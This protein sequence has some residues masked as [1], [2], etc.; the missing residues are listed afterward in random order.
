MSP[1]ARLE[2]SG[3][4]G[5]L[6]GNELAPAGSRRLS[7]RLLLI[8]PTLRAATGEMY[9]QTPTH[10]EPISIRAA[11]V[12]KQPTSPTARQSCPMDV[13]RMR[14]LS[15][16]DRTQGAFFVFPPRVRLA[17]RFMRFP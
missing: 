8:A 12:R 7:A 17:E 15:G 6:V 5:E 10:S 13:R 11:I 14:N 4:F 9:E 3:A 2:S 16:V 1:L